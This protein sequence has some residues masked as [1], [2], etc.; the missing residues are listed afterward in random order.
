MH[1]GSLYPITNSLEQSV[2]GEANR[3]SATR[4]IPR[5]VW[6]PGVP[7]RVHKNPLPVPVLSQY[8]P[9]HAFHPIY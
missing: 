7:Y 5:I 8:K 6:N 1:W 4:E 9:D 2:S 3:S